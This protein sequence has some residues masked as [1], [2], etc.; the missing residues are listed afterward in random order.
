MSLSVQELNGYIRGL[1]EDG[2]VWAQLDLRGDIFSWC[3]TKQD[4][5]LIGVVA[6]SKTIEAY[7]IAH[8][9]KDIE[10]DVFRLTFVQHSIVSK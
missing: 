3:T 10:R 8:S 5:T 6:A 1:C 7:N 2:T 4:A 9:P